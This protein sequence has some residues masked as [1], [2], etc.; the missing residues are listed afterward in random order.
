MDERATEPQRAALQQV[1]SGQAGGW[2]GKFAS[3]VGEVRGLEFV[4]IAFELVKAKL[5]QRRAV[6]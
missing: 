2:M 3:L 1:F 6:A 4:P 5:E